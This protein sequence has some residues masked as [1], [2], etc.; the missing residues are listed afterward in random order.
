MPLR[1]PGAIPVGNINAGRSLPSVILQLTGTDF[2]SFTHAWITTDATPFHIDWGD[3]SSE[4]SAS[5]STPAHSYAEVGDYTVRLTPAQGVQFSN[6][7]APD[8]PELT[9]LSFPVQVMDPTAVGGYDFRNHN[10][11]A[12]DQTTFLQHLNSLHGL[13]PSLTVHIESE[14]A[15]MPTAAA[16][17]PVNEIN[18]LGVIL[19]VSAMRLQGAEV[20]NGGT[21]YEN[22]DILTVIAGIGYG[23]AEA[24]LVVVGLAIAGVVQTLNLN[25][26]GHYLA[27]PGDPVAT[28][29]D[30]GIGI[31][32]TFNGTWMRVEWV[33]N[34]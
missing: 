31:D 34:L 3:G 19:F 12:A 5:S 24:A 1:A 30:T 15:P 32:C 18:A 21:G 10:I 23:D 14:T 22:D 16:K 13:S 27:V 9:G 33:P 26:Q 28:F 29:A 2:A 11:N 6:A 20:A 17:T 7:G 25:T 4:D 8:V